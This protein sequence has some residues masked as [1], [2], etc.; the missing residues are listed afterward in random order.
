M[1]VLLGSEAPRWR[2]PPAASSSRGSARRTPRCG[3]RNPWG[4]SRPPVKQTELVG[5]AGRLDPC[6]LVEIVEHV[7][8]VGADGLLADEQPRC[9]LPVGEPLGEQTQDL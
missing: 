5:A 8:E 9:D 3:I 2:L 6:V 1:T 4:G 7:R